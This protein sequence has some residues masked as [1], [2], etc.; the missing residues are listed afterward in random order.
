VRNRGLR[1]L[2]QQYAD[3]VAWPEALGEEKIREPVRLLRDVPKRIAF[4][5][6]VLALVDQR[7]PITVTGGDVLV[8]RI[9]SDV[10]ARRDGPA[11]S[12]ADVIICL[13]GA[14]HSCRLTQGPTTAG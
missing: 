9:D 4:D 10:V 12:A 6:A 5:G 2:R 8:D 7:Q 14:Q 11:E 1:P 3:A 13:G